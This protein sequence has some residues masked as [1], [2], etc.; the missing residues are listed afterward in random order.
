MKR[1][2][3]VDDKSNYEFQKKDL[4]SCYDIN[5][6]RL[7]NKTIPQ[8]FEYTWERMVAPISV[9][10]LRA[11][12]EFYLEQLPYYGEFR[13]DILNE[14]YLSLE[15]LEDD[16]I[17]LLSDGDIDAQ[18][19]SEKIKDGIRSVKKDKGTRSNGIMDIDTYL[20]QTKGT[21]RF[22]KIPKFGSGVMKLWLGS[23][24][25]RT[26]L[27]ET[28]GTTEKYKMDEIIKVI[29]KAEKTE[30]SMMSG[31]KITLSKGGKELSPKL[32]NK[33]EEVD[34]RGVLEYSHTDAI[35]LERI[36]GIAELR[37]FQEYVAPQLNGNENCISDLLKSITQYHGEYTRCFLIRLLGCCLHECGGSNL[38]DKNDILKGQRLII[39]R[40]RDIYNKIYLTMH[41]QILKK[42]GKNYTLQTTKQLVEENIQWTKKMFYLT[43]PMSQLIIE[44]N[45]K[46]L[47]EL[48]E[49]DAWDEML[50][51]LYDAKNRIPD[52]C[53][54][55]KKG[56]YERNKFKGLDLP[57][58]EKN[59]IDANRLYYRWGE[60]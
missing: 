50:K 33:D 13:L 35:I 57:D 30:K 31:V 28:W 3:L 17:E 9:S 49:H 6:E 20:E 10:N 51:I 16:K 42:Y 58:I 4:D 21:R 24:E 19:F 56:S 15:Y 43:M 8:E 59:I 41:N 23:K 1:Y 7:L 52:F 14:V 34:Y 55:Y 60:I 32:P 45:K 12:T 5:F 26:V 27:N 36:L 47:K 46:M 48:A 11:R 18:E 22:R 2:C 40:N 53:F 44:S 29:E 37:E 54:E 38:Y 39:D 25:F